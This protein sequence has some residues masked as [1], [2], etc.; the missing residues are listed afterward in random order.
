MRWMHWLYW[1]LEKRRVR[2]LY[3]RMS[4]YPKEDVMVERD[5]DILSFSPKPREHRPMAIRKLQVGL[6]RPPYWRE[7]RPIW[8]LMV[9]MS[10]N[11]G[12]PVCHYGVKPQRGG[13]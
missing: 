5:D 4:G 13:G 3:Q 8:G 12:R 2:L 10:G 6:E 11:W 7:T 1:Y 9:S